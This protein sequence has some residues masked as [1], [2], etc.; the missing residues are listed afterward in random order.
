[1]SRNRPGSSPDRVR[2]E[3]IR[4]FQVL[5]SPESPHFQFTGDGWTL[6][7]FMYRLTSDDDVG[8]VVRQVDDDSKDSDGEETGRILLSV[9][10]RDSKMERGPSPKMLSAIDAWDYALRQLVNGARAPAVGSFSVQTIPLFEYTAVVLLD[11]TACQV[12]SERNG[13]FRIYLDQYYFPGIPVSALPPWTRLSRPPRSDP[14]EYLT[15]RQLTVPADI[16]SPAATNPAG[17]GVFVRAGV[18]GVSSYDE[19]KVWYGR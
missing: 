14:P 6:H 15:T 2:H 19:Y 4:F 3:A 18:P 11:W 7:G 1:M 5:M 17:A 16:P 13:A 8:V 9:I 10:T 12:R